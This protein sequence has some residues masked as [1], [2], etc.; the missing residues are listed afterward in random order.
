MRKESEGHTVQEEQYHVS[1]LGKGNTYRTSI[2]TRSLDL[3]ETSA[4][5]KGLKVLESH[6]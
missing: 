5:S 6:I 3:L 4:V 1:S 2:P